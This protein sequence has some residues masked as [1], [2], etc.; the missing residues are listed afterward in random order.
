VGKQSANPANPM[1]CL[2]SFQKSKQTAFPVRIIVLVIG[3]S[4]HD[5]A[6]GPLLVMHVMGGH[7]QQM[8]SC[9]MRTSMPKPYTN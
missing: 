7:E 2:T 3:L 5:G 9:S 4:I 6:A 1:T 8:T